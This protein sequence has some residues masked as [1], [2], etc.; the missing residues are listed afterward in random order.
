[1]KFN[2]ENALDQVLD[3]LNGWLDTFIGMLPNMAVALLIF[4]AFL[5]LAK[6]TRNLILKVFHRASNNKA[7]ENLFATVIYYMVI[8]LGLFIIL[9]VLKMQ[10][11]VTSLLAGVGVVGLAL[12]FAFQDIAANFVSGVILA[13]RRPFKIGDIVSI[14]DYMGTVVRTNLRVTT[15]KTFQGQEVYLPNKDVLQSPIINYTITGERRIDLEVGVSYGDDLSKVQQLVLK[16]IKS[17]D[18]LIRSDDVIFD[19]HEF[20]SSSIN[21]FVRFWIEYPDQPGFLAMRNKAIMAIKDTFDENE[22]TIP[23]PIRT[24][25]FGIKGGEKLSEMSLQLAGEASNSN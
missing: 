25:D 1:M 9:G 8:G 4:I 18:G 19:Y 11:A 24:L 10:T 3:K 14:T 23:F 17:L 5:V 21:F 12:G 6:I 22:I 13:F 20:G 2:F 7:L 16:A 15:V